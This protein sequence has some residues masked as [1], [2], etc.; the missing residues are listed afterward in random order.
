MQTVAIYIISFITLVLIQF[1][2]SIVTSPNEHSFGNF[3]WGCVKWSVII[4]IPVAI[5]TLEVLDNMSVITMDNLCPTLLL[6][7]DIALNL[8]YLIIC[9]LA[10]LIEIGRSKEE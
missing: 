4:I 9:T 6:I 3:F 8:L 10:A 2:P 5:V 7:F 1:M